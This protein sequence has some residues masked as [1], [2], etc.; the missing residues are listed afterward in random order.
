MSDTCSLFPP[1]EDPWLSCLLPSQKASKIVLSTEG[2][3]YPYEF[4]ISAFQFSTKGIALIHRLLG[5]ICHINN[6]NSF[7][8]QT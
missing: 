3:A 2:L 1:F 6:I 8:L 4:L 7:N 5:G